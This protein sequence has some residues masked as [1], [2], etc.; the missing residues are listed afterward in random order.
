[1]TGIQVYVGPAR[2]A[3]LEQ[4]VAKRKS[5]AQKLPQFAEGSGK[6]RSVVKAVRARYGEDAAR[7]YLE[8][9]ARKHAELTVMLEGLDAAIARKRREM[10]I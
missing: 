10:G 5:L 3:S 8:D 9:A 4:L 2:G 6:V 1:M 7:R